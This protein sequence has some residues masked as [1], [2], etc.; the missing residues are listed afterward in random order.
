MSIYLDNAATTPLSAEV[1]AAMLPYMKVHYGNPSSIH[2]IG[3][4]ARTAVERARRS[5]ADCLQA[6]VG[7]IF[8]T[9]GGTESNNLALKGAV[10]DLGVR[11]IITSELEHHCVL[12]TVEMLEKAYGV[13]KYFVSQSEKGHLDLTSLEQLL[14]DLSNKDGQV[15]VSLM[16]G[17]NEIGNL[18][19]L[20]AVSIMCQNYGALFHT[21]TVQTFG[22]YPIDVQ[23]TKVHFLTGSGHKLHGPKGVGFLYI[24]DEINIQPNMLGGSQ[25]RN[26]RAGTENVYGIVG[27]AKAATLA[28][29]QIV[30]NEAY[31]SDL[32]H[33]LME[34]LQQMIPDVQFNGDP[35]GRSTCKVL[36]VAFPA[37][38]ESELLLLHLDIAGIC[39][40]GGSACSSGVDV[41]S[42][43]IN[44]LQLDNNSINIRFSFSKYNTKEELNILLEK[45]KTILKINTLDTKT[46]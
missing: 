14:Q 36:N 40:S 2:M 38:K 1:L 16:H 8:F 22:F 10:R 31:I 12:H 28:H 34:E 25:E 45:L 19:D 37:N 42:H 35:S 30:E 33:Y 4:K 32:K 3:R 20:D 11:H 39:A 6:S 18:L 21:D 44:A 5:I 23:K 29:E 43:V 13:K 9:S 41:G 17:N 7:E 26:M 46:I 15:L 24:N 27:L